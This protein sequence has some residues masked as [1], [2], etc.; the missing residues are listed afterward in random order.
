MPQKN[1]IGR[2]DPCPCGNNKK[3][4]HC[5]EGKVDWNGIFR[6]GADPNPY[7][8][9]RGRNIYFANRL[10]EILQFDKI[11]KV[12]VLKDYKAAF[13]AEA[14]GRIH[15]AVM[16][17]WPQN[18]DIVS[19]LRR[20]SVDVSGLYIGD[21]GIEYLTK[22]IVRHSIYA[23]KILVVDP[24][25]YPPSVRNEYNPLIEP[26]QYRAQTLKNVNFW[27]SLLPWV[28]AGIVEIIRTPADFDR[29]LNWDSM[30][31]QQEKF[32]TNQELKEA[33]EESVDE[34]T[35]RHMQKQAFEHLILGAPDSYL[36]RRFQ[37]SGAGAHGLTVEQF[38]EYVKW[39]RER[40]PDF[41]EPLSIESGSAQLHM[42][43]TGS[44]YE[45]ARLTANITKSYLVTDLH[46]KWREIELDR[47]SQSAEDKAWS[48]FAKAMQ[49]A[50]LKY[51]N[52]LSLDH[53]LSLRKEG[54]LESFRT[55]L[56]KVWKSACT[57]DPF[58]E[59]NALLLAEELQE[60][61]AEAE[62]E[63]KQIDRDLLKTVGSGLA[64]GLLAAGPLIASGHARFLAGAA[65]TA[66]AVNL[67]SST[68]KRR[69][70]PN[71][72]PAAFFMKMKI[73]K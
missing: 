64:A 37:E 26:K 57:E 69:D 65:A 58:D 49:V 39:E 71:R 21:Y 7:L 11:D 43:T 16:E 56:H 38:I 68:V 34:L 1:K 32:N 35:K 4:K 13:T 33:A 19:V 62:Q 70:F 42:M 24:F 45:I 40:N 48:P 14:V 8:S 53:A 54:R 61:V 23:N 15:E 66:G 31:H 30:V 10:A 12:R 25:V 28:L 27:F 44:N 67:I 22:G 52:A 59:T 3:Y 50:N 5:C 63:W 29:K 9:I 55:F 17:A 47:A 51:L 6:T 60:K 73:D 20:A 36:R 2:N 46:L 72:F 18:L 41:L